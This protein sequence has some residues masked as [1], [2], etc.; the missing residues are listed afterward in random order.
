MSRMRLIL[1][2]GKGSH[3]IKAVRAGSEY[4]WDCD[5]TLPSSAWC[6]VGRT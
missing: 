4:L 5:I 3:F 6:G 2:W 1:R